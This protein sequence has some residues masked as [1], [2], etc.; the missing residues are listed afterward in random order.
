MPKQTACEFIEECPI[1]NNLEQYQEKM[2]IGLYCTRNYRVCARRKLR[3]QNHP[4][5][6]D[7]GPHGKKL[8]YVDAN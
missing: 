6:D 4:V 5:P 7:L 2:Y 3:L 1:F 8:L